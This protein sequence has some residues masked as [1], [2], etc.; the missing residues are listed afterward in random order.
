MA[1]VAKASILLGERK[2]RQILEEQE[3]LEQEKKLEQKKIL[4]EQEAAQLRLEILREN[5]QM[6]Q[7]C[8]MIPLAGEDLSGLV[9]YNV[10]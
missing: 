1:V 9:G 2:K 7:Y 8:Y 10:W 3:V 4:E 6:A 5:N